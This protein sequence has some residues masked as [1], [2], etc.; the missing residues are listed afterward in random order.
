MGGGTR[1]QSIEFRPDGTFL[2][3]GVLR[4]VRGA[5]PFSASGAWRVEDEYLI[6]NITQANGPGDFLQTER[7]SRIVSISE[8]EL[9]TTDSNTD[10]EERAWRYP[11][12]DAISM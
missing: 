12:E 10:L 1:Q 9:V 3:A 5:L 7:R 4:N 8:W 2:I 11:N 6:L